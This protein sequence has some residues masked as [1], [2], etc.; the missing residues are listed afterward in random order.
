MYRV[1]AQSVI[2]FSSRRCRCFSGGG[3]VEGVDDTSILH[4]ARE[5]NAHT[6]PA[7]PPRPATNPEQCNK[8]NFSYVFQIEKEWT[9]VQFISI[10]AKEAIDSFGIQE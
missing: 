7:K 3:G 4:M 10:D 5:F 2:Q 8:V 1:F 9:Q 6:P